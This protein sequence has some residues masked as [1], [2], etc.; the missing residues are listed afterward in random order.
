MGSI[1]DLLKDANLKEPILRKVMSLVPKA[2]EGLLVAS[3]YKKFIIDVLATLG[4]PY[5]NRLDIET[6]RAI[7]YFRVEKCRFEE[8]KRLKL[9]GLALTEIP[10]KVFWLKQLEILDLSDNQLTSIPDQI[11]ELDKLKTLVLSINKLSELPPVLSKLEQLEKIIIARNLIKEVRIASFPSSLRWINLSDNQ[12]GEF[13]LQ[14]FHSPKL[15]GVWLCNN[16]I[17][18]LGK[19]IYDHIKSHGFLHAIYLKGNPMKKVPIYTWKGNCLKSIRTYL[20][21]AYKGTITNYEAKIVLVG[22]GNEGKTTLRARLCFPD[23]P[24][25]KTST[26]LGIEIEAMDFRSPIRLLIREHEVLRFRDE[27]NTIKYNA[28]VWD[29]GGQEIQRNIH[30]FFL[31]DNAL[32]LLLWTVRAGGE[33]KYENIKYWLNT[34]YSY[35]PNA[36]IIIILNKAFDEKGDVKNL[37]REYLNQEAIKKLYPNVVDFDEISAKHDIGIEGENG[38]RE[39][40]RVHLRSLEKVGEELPESWFKVKE[41]LE[42][43]SKEHPFIDLENFQDEALQNPDLGLQGEDEFQNI[44]NWLKNI[45]VILHYKRYPLN[46]FLF[47][48]PE[49]ITKPVYKVLLDEEGFIRANNGQFSRREFKKLSGLDKSN[50]ADIVLNLMVHFYLCVKLY[51]EQDE[52]IVPQLLRDM[53]E[54]ELQNLKINQ[55]QIRYEYNYIFQPKGLLNR[56]IAQCYRERLVKNQQYWNNAIILQ[57]EDAEAVVFSEILRRDRINIHVKGKSSSTLLN[58]INSKFKALNENAQI[59]SEL[60]YCNCPFCLRNRSNPAT[61]HRGVIDDMRK[62]EKTLIQ[63]TKCYEMVPIAMLFNEPDK[64]IKQ[65][66]NETANQP[67][68]NIYDISADSVILGSN[69]QAGGSVEVGDRTE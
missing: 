68:T 6:K 44:I 31:T 12:L 28:K 67:T 21:A 61:Y 53:D 13:P 19:E 54:D 5:K 2:E 9:N 45:G 35:S 46:Q 55:F 41:N 11:S 38:L 18:E 65:S 20:E 33:D 15:T 1:S 63:C 42:L 24:P 57:T 34:I 49:W 39:K 43:I 50:E 7:A 52:F 69:I 30:S 56:F 14:V 59:E 3:A 58:I 60:I 48:K 25:S 29:F 62:K 4:D 8:K 10:D 17:N 16:E 40:I 37:E 47:L 23:T 26:T 27:K 32:Y 51:E 66:Q 22:N 36:K 64:R